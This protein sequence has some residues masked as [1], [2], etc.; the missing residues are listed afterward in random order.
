MSHE[1][2]QP[3]STEAVSGPEALSALMDGELSAFEYR[4]LIKELERHPEWLEQWEQFHLIR[5]G[6]RAEPWA[7]PMPAT[8][9]ADGLSLSERIAAEVAVAVPESAVNGQT[10]AGDGQTSALST[11]GLSW[12]QM[13]ARVAVAATVALAVFAGM[14]NML[15]IDG[16]SSPATM[17]SSREQL[18]AGDLRDISRS[19]P[20]QMNQN[21]ADV[22]SMVDQD[23][24]QRLN[25]YIRSVSIPSRSAE[26]TAPFN[27]LRESPL[28]R[29]VSD[30]ELIPTRESVDVPEQ[31]QPDTP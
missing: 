3:V 13:T 7:E 29:P 19:S 15:A 2:H 18:N 11:S 20:D 26:Q 8:Q 12:R 30:R 24:Q 14:Q 6:L 17:M 27:I 9:R 10:L 5:D 1:K 23:A 21:I 25:D 28:L 4:R 31:A 22:S 16:A